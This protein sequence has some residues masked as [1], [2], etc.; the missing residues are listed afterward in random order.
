MQQTSTKEERCRKMLHL[1][2]LCSEMIISRR[3]PPSSAVPFPFSKWRDVQNLLDK[4][5]K[6]MN[7]L[8]RKT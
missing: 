6:I 2:A 5:G 1:K 4:A 8:S 7:V 3:L